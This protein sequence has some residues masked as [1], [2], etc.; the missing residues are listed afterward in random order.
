MQDEKEIIVELE[1]QKGKIKK[2][3][4]VLQMFMAESK[5]RFE[6]QEK[7]ADKLG[8]MVKEISDGLGDRMNS[9]E[10]KMAYFMG[11]LAVLTLL[12]QILIK[13]FFK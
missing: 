13:I 10:R 12:F 1:K 3:E 6:Q 4:T 5:R 11:G 2:L 9:L 7:I 8:D